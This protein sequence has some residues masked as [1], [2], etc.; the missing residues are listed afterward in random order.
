MR[1]KSKISRSFLPATRS[2]RGTAC[3]PLEDR[4]LLAAFVVTSAQDNGPGTLRQAILDANADGGADTIDFDI[5]GAGVHT[6]SLTSQLPA[7]TDPVTIDGYSQPGASRNTLAQGDNAVLQI[8]I[9]V[10]NSVTAPAGAN[11]LVLQAAGATIEG[12]IIDGFH[13]APENAATGNAIVIQDPGGDTIAGN[14]LGMS[15]TGT[16]GVGNDGAG[17]L[18]EAG[19]GNTIGGATPGDRNV[20]S[21]NGAA[22]I[23]TE[24]P[25]TSSNLIEGN[26]IGTDPTGT[27]AV[28]NIGPGINVVSSSGNTIGGTSPAASNVI[29]GN[30]NAGITLGGTGTTG[31]LIEGNVIGADVT[32]TAPLGNVGA[33]IFVGNSDAAGPSALIETNVIAF[34]V[35]AKAPAT[36]AGVD[37][38]GFGAVS[39][40]ILSN[41]IFG[42]QGLGIDLGG[43]GVT[44]NHTVPTAGPNDFQNFPVIT[45]VTAGLTTTTVAGTLDSTPNQTFTIELFSNTAADASGFGQGQ[46]PLGQVPVTTDAKGHATFSASLP[47]IATGQLVISATATSATGNTSE[48]SQDFTVPALPDLSLADAASPNPVL[49]G[50]ILTYTLTIQNL[51]VGTATGVVLTDTLPAA[52]TFVNGSAPGSVTAK[53]GV[54]TASAGTL[55]RGATATVTINVRARSTGTV[56]DAASVSSNETDSNPNNNTASAQVVIVPAADLAV[57]LNATPI[58][59]AKGAR[60]PT[61]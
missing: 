49:N 29:S 28:A 46:T 58:P 33:G 14:S 41:A 22:G 10:P 19:I 16:A 21:G 57:G 30:S 45:A 56:S 60:L 47:A 52:V 27:V 44:P 2:F 50:Q 35:A 25:A 24:G 42:N 32:G 53:N 11:G 5:A 8:E 26:F 38:V 1:R 61:W 13:S 48:F 54:V 55:A 17:V 6:I 3:E 15:P 7:I 18:V 39:N 31:E 51:G 4:V 12:L 36:G 43:D 20:I 37:V 23:D 34:N 59:L 40:T 9:T